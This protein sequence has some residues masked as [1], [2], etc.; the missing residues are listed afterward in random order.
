MQ[1]HENRELGPVATRVLFEND[2]VKVWEMDLKPGEVC[3]LHRHT[4]DYV[5]F[6]LEGANLGVESPGSKPFRFDVTARATYFV[7]SGGVESAHNVGDTRFFEALF[8]IKRKARP[9]AEHL[10][11]VGCEAVAG[12]DP[13]PGS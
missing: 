8:E 9:G 1:S 10:G 6:I 3:G 5:L 4:M 13:Q 12:K 7:P 11:F 2:D